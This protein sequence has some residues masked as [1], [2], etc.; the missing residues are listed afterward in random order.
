[1]RRR[2]KEPHNEAQTLED[3]RELLYIQVCAPSGFAADKMVREFVA[4][5]THDPEEK[6]S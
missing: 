6:D 5:R 4:R 1:M 2:F 3:I